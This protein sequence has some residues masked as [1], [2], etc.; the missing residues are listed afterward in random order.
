MKLK[1]TGLKN[2][3]VFIGATTGL[4]FLTNHGEEL[5]LT[6]GTGTYRDPFNA[7]N[8]TQWTK[9]F[10]ETEINFGRYKFIQYVRISE[11]K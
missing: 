3:E 4:K 6:S 5:T 9:E 1:I 11:N 10:L 7:S 2:S 8:K